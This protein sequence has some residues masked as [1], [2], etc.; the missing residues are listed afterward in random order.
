MKPLMQTTLPK[1][2]ATLLLPFVSTI[3]IAIT[4][5]AIAAPTTATA[6]ENETIALASQPRRDPRNTILVTGNAEIAATP[7][8]AVVRFG[9]TAQNSRASVAQSKVNEVIQKTIEAL[10]KAGVARHFVRTARISLTPIYSDKLLSAG[11]YKVSSFRADNVLEVT[12]DDM[13]NLGEIIDAA[14]NAGANEIHGVYFR[15]QDDGETRRSALANAARDAKAKAQ[16]I[17]EGLGLTLGDVIEANETATFSPDTIESAGP[18]VMR[19][20]PA[21]EISPTPVEPGQLR[22][23]AQV[24]VRYEIARKSSQ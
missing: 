11:G 17:A 24:I 3:A 22:F 16:K 1:S 7:D 23:Q 19:A 10:Q 18:Q 9:M 14:I 21:K 6:A 8:Q 5:I 12:V 4:T 2:L 15:L 13:K 20:F